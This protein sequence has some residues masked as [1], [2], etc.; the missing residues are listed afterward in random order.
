MKICFD[1]LFL[2]RDVIHHNAI[3]HSTETA[4]LCISSDNTSFEG[5][6]LVQ[7]RSFPY[8][9]LIVD[10]IWRYDRFRMF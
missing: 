8:D 9:A 2:Y 10:L 4:Y 1:L 7:F 3:K 5:G 6:F